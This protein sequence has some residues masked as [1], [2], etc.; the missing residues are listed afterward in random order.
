MSEV[1]NRFD[2]LAPIYDG[3]SKIVFGKSIRNAQLHFLKYSEGK[4]NILILG[5]GTGWIVEE[6]IRINP[7]CSV[8]YI[9]ASFK[10]IEIAQNKLKHQS[11]RAIHFIHGTE[12]SIPDS[13][14]FDLVITNFYLDLFSGN[15]LKSIIKIIQNKLTAN[16]IWLASDFIDSKEVYQKMLLKVMYYFFKS[17]CGIEASELPE[18]ENKIKDAGIKEIDSELFYNG[19]IKSVA[20]KV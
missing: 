3:L 12:Q 14:E 8:W 11:Q 6:L 16:A 10:M 9:E 5:G 7:T 19:F 15:S 13:V 4:K 2:T 18:W 17:V 20:Y 1:L